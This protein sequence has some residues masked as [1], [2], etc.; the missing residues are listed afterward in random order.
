[1]RSNAWGTLHWVLLALT[2]ACAVVV[3]YGF[4]LRL[5]PTYIPV[6]AVARDNALVIAWP[7][8]FTR[9]SEDATVCV[10]DGVTLALSPTDRISGTT[11]VPNNADSL[12]VE[13]A[14]HRWLHDA[15]GIVRFVALPSPAS[16]NTVT[17]AVRTRTFGTKRGSVV[18]YKNVFPPIGSE[19]LTQQPP[20]ATAPPGHQ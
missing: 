5:Q 4:Y 17:P 12:K 13:V 9:D 1:M 6:T 2:A 7:S 20:G 14:V 10:N 15:R 3:A 18:P 19:G 11:V 8:S 16:A